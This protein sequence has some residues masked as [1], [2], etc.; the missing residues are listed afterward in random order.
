M[1]TTETNAIGQWMIA[2]DNMEKLIY[3]CYDN[4]KAFEAGGEAWTIT[5]YKYSLERHRLT[6]EFDSGEVLLIFEY[7]ETNQ[8][9]TVSAW[10]DCGIGS[11]DTGPDS[12]DDGRNEDS[13][14]VLQ[15]VYKLKTESRT[16]PEKTLMLRDDMFSFRFI[17]PGQMALVIFLIGRLEKY[18]GFK[19]K[20]HFNFRSALEFIRKRQ[21]LADAFA[22]M[23]TG[24]VDPWRQ[25]AKG[26]N[27]LSNGS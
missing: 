1:N 27:T 25:A 18:A 14:L 6:V 19:T 8:M 23:R 4:D 15:M 20:K 24:L 21:T 16:K 13:V 26:W 2:V 9:L 5:G 12:D 7:S 10:Q 3:K 17:T 11:D 22:L